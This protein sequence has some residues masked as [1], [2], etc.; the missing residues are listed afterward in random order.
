MSGGSR[1]KN[2]ISQ[3]FHSHTSPARSTSVAVDID[4]REYKIQI[5][6]LAKT[7]IAY[8]PSIYTGMNTSTDDDHLSN[9]DEY[10]WALFMSAYAAGRWDPFE[11]PR[12]PL[13]TNSAS[14]SVDS[15][16]TYSA[17]RALDKIDGFTKT[18]RRS[19][20]NESYLPSNPSTFL[21]P[22]SPSN[23][24]P[25]SG[26]KTQS[27]PMSHAS[28]ETEDIDDNE[29]SL[30]PINLSS[31]QQNLAFGPELAVQVATHSLIHSD[32]KNKKLFKG[33]E[34]ITDRPASAPE[35]S[36]QRDLKSTL[37]SQTYDETN[38]SA[39]DYLN[40]VSPT[41][42]SKV[43]PL[44]TNDRQFSYESELSTDTS[45]PTNTRPH[46]LNREDSDRTVMNDATPSRHPGQPD[47]DKLTE[48]FDHQHIIDPTS[49]VT[50]VKALPVEMNTIKDPIPSRLSSD[51][52]Q[53]LAEK[54]FS[55]LSYLVPPLPL[56]EDARRKELFKF[57]LL[58]G[59]PDLSLDR[60]LHLVKLV[61]QT[62]CVIISLV[63]GE[64]VILKAHT[65]YEEMFETDIRVNEPRETALSSH[66][67]LQQNDE[68]L[69]SLDITKDWRF[70][71]N[72]SFSPKA[73]FYAAAPIRTYNGYNI[74]ALALIDS[75]PRTEF[76]PRQR[77]TLKEF[78]SI[79]LREMELW[80]DKCQMR[81]RDL[82]QSSMEQFN[83]D[84]LEMNSAGNS[85]SSNISDMQKVYDKAAKL[86]KD[87]L[88]VE[89]ALV[90]DISQFEIAE[91][92]GDDNELYMPVSVISNRYFP[93]LRP[94]RTLS[95]N[96]KGTHPHELAR[97]PISLR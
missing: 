89:G 21:E 60:I 22:Q 46:F 57:D 16:R 45:T 37:P 36:K 79:V 51:R 47:L 8:L 77:H 72:P 38:Q 25:I 52:I 26:Q 5:T 78:A 82:I 7:P 93:Y 76:T 94:L 18:R 90:L 17:H 68:P 81:T 48:A 6:R 9:P 1:D 96:L 55:E 28:S 15:R 44:N 27:A 58:R 12:P 30:Y 66:A 91:N 63:N 67:I 39:T 87:T 50:S 10:D 75:Q 40:Y 86:I 88:G 61:F 49:P 33:V 14:L 62:K 70:S 69:V 56:N 11:I 35:G 64:N 97:L 32:E 29:P 3:S 19:S 4:K 24:K 84:I 31:T 34:D 71:K 59:T 41:P 53:G 65:G 13:K 42:Q 23:S 92:L 43:A 95:H 20:I 2:N 73:R 54:Q 80:R 74:G 85:K 83:R